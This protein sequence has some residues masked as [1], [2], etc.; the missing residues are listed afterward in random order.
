MGMSKKEVKFG[1][2]GSY[3]TT[4][5]FRCPVRGLVEQEVVVKKFAAQA[6]PE[7]KSTDSVVA[8]LLN[9]EEISDE[10]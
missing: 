5:K 9:Q 4:I 10:D 6:A 8:E 1:Q 2:E 3:R 7:S